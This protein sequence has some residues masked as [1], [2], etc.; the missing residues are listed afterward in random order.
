MQSNII[1]CG[2]IRVDKYFRLHV[3]KQCKSNKIKYGDIVK[4]TIEKVER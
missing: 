4:V 2:E 3:T 1:D